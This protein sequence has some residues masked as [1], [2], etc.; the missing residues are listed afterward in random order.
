M[1]KNFFKKLA[2]VLTLALV[3][4]S[5]P[6]TGANAAAAPK[7]AKTYTNVYDGSS[8]AYSVSNVKKGY[9]VKWSVSGAGKSYVSLAAKSAKA[10][11]KVATKG[12][13][14]AAN[15]SA[16]VT[17]KVYNGKKVV[18]TAS[19]S[20]V[21]KI[22]AT[23]LDLKAADGV[24]L[25]KVALDTATQLN[26]VLT[27]ANST[28]A[29]KFA[30]TDKDGK[31][32]T[33]ATVDAKGSFKA[34]AVGTYKVTATVGTLTKTVDVVVGY[35][36]TAKQTTTTKVAVVFNADVSKV[37]T[38]DN[39]AITNA[40][41]VKQ[42]IKAVTFSTDGKT[43][44]A[45]VYVAF[46]DKEV[47]TVAYDTAKTTF[48]ASKGDVA[49]VVVTAKTVQYGTPTKFD[50]ALFDA[51][52]V[53]VTTATL[54]SN[55]VTFTVD[56][57]L[58]NIAYDSSAD[59][60]AITVYSYDKSVDVKATFHTYTY[61]D[62]K[63]VAYDSDTVKFNSVK[64]IKGTA[65]GMTATYVRSGKSADWNNLNNV[66]TIGDT[67]NMKVKGVN[68]DG[69]T[70]Y[71]SAMTFESTDT[72]V[73][74]VS[75]VTSGSTTTVYVQGIKAGSAYIK[76][77]YGDT[78]QLFPINVGALSEA[79]SVTANDVTVYVASGSQVASNAAAVYPTVKDQYGN[80]MDIAT[81]GSESCSIVTTSNSS[82][83]PVIAHTTG[84][85][86]VTGTALALTSSNNAGTFTYKYTFTDGRTGKAVSAYFNVTTVMTNNATASYIAFDAS[87]K[88]ADISDSTSMN[89]TLTLYDYNN[90]GQVVGKHIV[91][92]SDLTVTF[93]GATVPALG[94]LAAASGSAIGTLASYKNNNDG[95]ISFY[96]NN[97]QFQATPGTYVVKA[98]SGASISAT[99]TIVVSNSG[100][101]VTATTK[102]AS[103]DASKA[104]SY[105]ALVGNAFAFTVD[106]NA[107][108]YSASAFTVDAVYGSLNS[109]TIGELGTS[110]F[111]AIS[112]TQVYV[113]NVVIHIGAT[114]NKM[115][116]P[117]NQ[118]ITIQ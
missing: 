73:A 16:K 77:T 31:A 85:Y 72:S 46:T 109:Q 61:K 25:T 87:S 12:A 93:N 32:T 3:V 15:A 7:F 64:E 49:K 17:Y 110:S 37:V 108:D 65:T 57:S 83:A 22:K 34:T 96:S 67:Y 89:P 14:K 70:V 116:I 10:T 56:N 114:G 24:D 115:V 11:L 26:V 81:A 36:M 35:A 84:V 51:N 4:T 23:A 42:T 9:T 21:I 74:T 95:T 88:N 78:V 48:T 92:A 58:A 60:Y 68:A 59:K 33:T 106:G 38:K 41:G 101:V 62:N 54:L 111:G 82:Y 94:T 69:T 13:A 104:G 103:L 98:V 53:D 117:V 1:K 75:K 39:L 63:E 2:S 43:A 100:S 45:E 102:A 79:N 80:K 28:D 55:K 107:L 19:D 76:C 6:Y 105:A 27:P 99:A 40:S 113:K 118:N 90:S 5:V 66:V 29:A 30:V 8:Y 18:K 44:T 47:Y 20:V 50:V 86:T 91:S 71:E 97:N 112:G 52:G